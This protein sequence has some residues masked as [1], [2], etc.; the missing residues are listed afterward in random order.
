MF[1]KKIPRKN[2][3][4]FLVY[5]TTIKENFRQ[6]SVDRSLLEEILAQKKVKHDTEPTIEIATCIFI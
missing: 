6:V 4:K 5:A 2:T 1:Q 3:P